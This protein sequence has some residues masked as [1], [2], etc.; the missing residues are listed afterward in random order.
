MIESEDRRWVLDCPRYL[1]GFAVLFWGVMFQQELVALGLCLVFEGYNFVQTRWNFTFSNYVKAWHL[2]VIIAVLIGFLYWLDGTKF[3]EMRVVFGWLPVILG[4][5]LFCQRYGESDTMPLSTFSI[6]ARY[7]LKADIKEGRPIRPIMINVAS[8]FFAVVILSAGL[9]RRPANFYDLF[10][11][12]V[13][14]VY[15]IGTLVLLGFFIFLVGKEK[16]RGIIAFGLVYIMMFFAGFGILKGLDKLEERYRGGRVEMADDIDMHESH[17]SI[18]DLGKIKLSKRVK[19]RMWVP[20]GQKIPKRVPFTIYNIYQGGSWNVSYTSITRKRLQYDTATKVR[21]E[22]GDV[23][24]FGGTTQEALALKKA[25]AYKFLSTLEH[26]RGEAMMPH[27]PGYFA[28]GGLIGIESSM[29]KT[30]LGSVQIANPEATLHCYLWNEDSERF[31]YSQPTEAFDKMIPSLDQRTLVQVV[32]S[33]GLRGMPPKEMIETLRA[34][35][36]NNFEYS[37][38]LD[39]TDDRGMDGRLKKSAL[40]IFLTESKK[41]HCEYFASAATLILRE[42]GLYT[43]YVNGYAVRDSERDGDAYLL[44][45]TQA[46]SWTNVW[47]DNKWVEVDLTPSSWTN[48][49]YIGKPSM[50][51]KLADWWKLMLEDFQL[52]RSDPTNGKIVNNS[53]IGIIIAMVLWVFLRLWFAKNKKKE[54]GFATRSALPKWKIIKR[55]DEWCKKQVGPRPLGMPYGQWV[56]QLREI[57]PEKQTSVENFIKAYNEV[58]FNSEAEEISDD[59]AGC[60]QS[61][62]KKS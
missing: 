30:P 47:I 10:T 50:M 31:H 38:H 4:P 52:W 5:L 21:G 60:A 35:F 44:R 41:G 24:Y 62:M 61:L 23:E 57:I 22:E 19:W 29:E 15:G 49:D 46:H 54:V 25:R 9:Y 26:N 6:L 39:I 36:K 13:S 59:L 37:Q 43:R 51:E 14:Q 16:G 7:R 27:L 20:L 18:G 40:S 2:S 58:R 32:D 8:P 56:G 55:F 45:G 48:Q 28:Y 17:T 11:Y 1:I 3:Q 42:A 34:H 33:L 12:D 53:I